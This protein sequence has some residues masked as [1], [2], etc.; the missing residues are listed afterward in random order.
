MAK[1]SDDRRAAGVAGRLEGACLGIKDLFCTDG[2]ASTA[3]SNL[4]RSFVPPYESTVNRQPVARWGG[5]C[6]AS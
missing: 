1:A 6:W 4:L 2:V 5:G 3:G